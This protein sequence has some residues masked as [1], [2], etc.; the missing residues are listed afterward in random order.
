MNSERKWSS[1][2]Y[3]KARAESQQIE[4][5]MRNILRLFA[6]G[7]LVYRARERRTASPVQTKTDR[8]KRLRGRNVA[9]PFQPGSGGPAVVA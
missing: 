7:N 1:E 5:L 4:T 6:E 8:L 3:K 2:A 9:V